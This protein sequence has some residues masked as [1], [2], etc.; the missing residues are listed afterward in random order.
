[1]ILLF[2][3]EK[4]MKENVDATVESGDRPSLDLLG[5]LSSVNLHI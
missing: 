1:M 5:C 4:K 3:V 2:V